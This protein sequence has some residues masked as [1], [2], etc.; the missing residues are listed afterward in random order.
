M[1]I[2]NASNIAQFQQ[3]AKFAA[4]SEFKAPAS[5]AKAVTS[6][7]VELPNITHGQAVEQQPS[8]PQLKNAVDSI[9]KFLQQSNRNIQFS[10]DADTQ[11]TVVK[12]IDS[13]TGDVIRQYPSKEV[14]EISRS[15]ENMQQGMLL[16][17]QA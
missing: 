9:N 17:Q 15:I 7:P 11:R 5:N 14:L 8:V 12:L 2:Q 3:H 1:L 16:R 10:V 4:Q 6:A 13:D